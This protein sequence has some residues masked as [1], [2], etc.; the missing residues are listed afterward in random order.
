VI[1]GKAILLNPPIC[2]FPL[3]L[4]V[5]PGGA[6]KEMNSIFVVKNFRKNHSETRGYGIINPVV[7]RDHVWFNPL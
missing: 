5:I 1:T 2:V 4:I 6:L 7:S 3:A